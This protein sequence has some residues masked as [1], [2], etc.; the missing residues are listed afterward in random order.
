MT[1]AIPLL[2]YSLAWQS[3]GLIAEGG[4]KDVRLIDAS[5]RRPVATLSGHADAVR[6]IAFSRDGK[7]LAAGGGLPA[8]KGEVKIWDVAARTLTT[9]ITGHSDCIYAVAFSPDGTTLATA[10]YDKLIKLWD[11]RTAREIRTLKDHID[12]V[13]A[14]EFTPD[15]KRLV[16]GSADRSV[17][18]TNVKVPLVQPAF[19]SV[20]APTTNRFRWSCV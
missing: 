14:L 7:L 9:T 11:V 8:R 13:Y 3:G 4:Y 16:S 12:A 20:G 5:T 10:S 1:A 17:N 2:I 19:G 18:A 6:A 15:G